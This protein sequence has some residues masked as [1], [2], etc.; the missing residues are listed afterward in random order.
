MTTMK[1]H[2]ILMA[3]AI[4]MACG[5]H[6]FAERIEIDAF[7]PPATY[8][9]GLLALPGV[10]WGI[11]SASA[12][13]EL[14]AP[15]KISMAMRRVADSDKPGHFGVELFGGD[16]FRAHFYSHDGSHFIAAL[17]QGETRVSTVSNR[18]GKDGFPPSADADW[19]PVDLYVQPKM[20]EI[21]IA[22][23]PR[24]MLPG[25]LLP[26]KK[27]S[28]YG[29][30][31]NVEVKDLAWEPLP[32]AE[33]VSTDPNPSFALTFDDGLDAWTAAGARPPLKAQ[34]I[35][36]NAGVA[37]RAAWV[38]GP[39]K[40][41][42][43]RPQ[44]EYDISGLA[45]NHGTL[46][47][48]VKSDWD[49]RYTGTMPHYPMLAAVDE[50]GDY[51]FAV[52]MSWW[53]SGLLGRTGDLRT[54]E[55]KHDSRADWH[56]GD[57]NHVALVW[58]DG[59]WCKLFFNGQPY[60]QPFGFNGKILTNL[61]LKSA[62]RLVFGSQNR[63]ADAAFDEVKLYKRPLD[64]GEVYD[65]YRRFMPVDMLLSRSHVLADAQETVEIQV[66]PGGHFLRPI[67]A[68]RPLRTGVFD[69]RVKVADTN[70]QVVAERAFHVP[71]DAPVPLRVPVAGL[72]VGDYRVVC[73]FLDDGAPTGMQRSFP[74]QA[75]TPRPAME[76]C[77][78]DL[79]LGDVIFEKDLSADDVLAAGGVQFVD[80]PIGRY[81][82]AGGRP[83][84]RFAFEVP[85][86]EK[87]RDGR[88]VLLE[89]V[90]PDDKPR[91]MGFYFYP[92]SARACHRDRLGGGIQSGEEYPLTGT[93]QTTRYLFHPGVAK[94][95]F[96]ARTMANGHPAALAAFRIREIKNARLPALKIQKP[97][98]LPGRR[99]GYR[100]EDQTF[101]QNLGWDYEGY[102]NV[103][104]MTERLLDYLDYTGQNAW[105]YPFMRYNGYGFDMQGSRHGD[106]YP[107]SPQAF[108]YMVEALARRGVM[109]IA[110]INLFTLPEMKMLPDR[111]GEIVARGWTL[112]KIGDPP[113][114]PNQYTR[115]NHAHPE[116]RAMIARHVAETATRFHATPGFGGVA[117]TTHNIGFHP[118]IDHGYD[119]FTVARF[120][121]E[122]GVDVPDGTPEER[123]AFLCDPSRLAAWEAWRIQ[124]SVLLFQAIRKALDAV[125]PGVA[126]YV[127]VTAT[128]ASDEMTAAIQAVKA[129]DR[130]EVVPMRFCTEHRHRLHWGKPMNDLNERLYD[131]TLA[132]TFV[133]DGGRGYVDCFGLY[134]ESF[135]GSLMNETYASY[136]QNADVKPFGRY[137]LKELVFAV[138]AMDAQRILIGAQ[139]LGTWG[140]DVE[141]RE[142]AQAYCALPALPFQ[143]AP[144]A[145]DPVTVR[146][147]NTPG[148]S[149]LYAASMLWDDCEAR[150]TL[151]GKAALEDLST[152]SRIADRRVAL[153]A[154]QLRS[155][156]S[157]DPELKVAAVETVVPDRVRDC[158]RRQIAAVQ[159]AVARLDGCAIACDEAEA[160]L[161]TMEALLSEN[162][163]AE[164]HRAL[165]SAAVREALDK[166]KNV[167][168]FA[169]QAEMIR[170]GH[171]AVNCG[172][173]EF[174]RTRR[175]LLFFPDQPF[176]KGGY[177]HVGPTQSVNRKIDGV[178][179]EDAEL[180]VSESYNF[181]A[182]RFEVAPG[183]YTVKL[184]LKTGYERSFKPGVYVFSV[185][186]EGR[187]VLEAFDVVAACD[188]DFTRV[189]VK[190]FE[191]VKVEDGTLDIRYIV[192][193]GSDTTVKMA[194]A[195]EVIRQEEEG[196]H[197]DD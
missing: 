44:L 65:E 51:R 56:R 62:S 17:H 130:V 50:Q 158:C 73:E 144:G 163:F 190:T 10:N 34:N 54:E 21:H 194:N 195:I 14:A 156:K 153:K 40:G 26:L 119:A 30:H 188:G 68:E 35:Q 85:F 123:Q 72:P 100:D 134:F 9:N 87:C 20:A 39:E 132:A 135:N 126:F 22:G 19:V 147:L 106:L 92:E 88:P 186:I 167:A 90:W 4:G 29:Y 115:P 33:A 52:Q 166:A 66:A 110:D 71:V 177:G 49:G 1:N 131:P 107:Y 59:G 32:G 197:A 80:A 146:V 120:S 196:P 140:R 168:S 83:M 139:P 145:Q 189:V 160:A 142:F 121:R 151:S 36:T 48:W 103:Q 53:I 98:D 94:Y 164:L 171:H 75:Y 172:S 38:G 46:M 176:A 162:R 67:P 108:P 12:D 77:H 31:N 37:G 7:K 137:F 42:R 180:F 5:A 141:T 165:F 74:L 193:P 117:M 96:E 154:Y 185:E 70:D 78:D 11:A 60:T 18:D 63:S 97:A 13:V 82:E 91:S 170:R 184:Y 161:G 175:G 89:M 173:T 3:L 47:F 6:A 8:A 114:Q 183:T 23:V 57:W 84:N 138:Y 76:P 24:G 43:L 111:T 136:F 187:P 102:R 182:Y 113:V 105:Q 79:E 25:N 41:A 45:A 148:G 109:T 143:N 64:N 101:D 181:D 93:M 61:D 124:Q 2:K 118:S 179:H 155:F 55:I 192:E 169:E 159:E 27:V 129:I 122:T 112:T 58:S 133:N 99:F 69:F 81:L 16:G 127:N 157:E 95:L 86:P 149:Y 191:N 116:I 125:D 150:L 15:V 104:A 178:D 128:P 174:L 28:L 152:G